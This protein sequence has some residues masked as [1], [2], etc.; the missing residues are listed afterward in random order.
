MIKNGWTHEENPNFINEAE[1][2]SAYEAEE[3]DYK[4]DCEE[5][6]DCE[7]DREPS[8]GNGADLP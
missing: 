1:Q 3:G 6:E 2:D 7:E 4:E 5:E 8:H